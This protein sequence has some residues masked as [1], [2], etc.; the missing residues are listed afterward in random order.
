LLSNIIPIPEVSFSI[1]T[2]SICFDIG[3]YFGEVTG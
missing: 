3:L 1:V 2:V